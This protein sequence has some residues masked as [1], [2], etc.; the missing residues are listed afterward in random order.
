MSFREFFLLL[1]H[2]ME[3]RV[4]FSSAEWF[5]I[6]VQ[7]FASI[8]VPR[9]EIPSCFLFC[10]RVP[11]EL[12]EL[13]SIFVSSE[14]NSELFS[15]PRK[16][17]ERNS[18][19]FL[20][21]GTAGIPSEIAICFVFRRFFLSEIPNPNSKWMD[22]GHWCLSKFPIT[23]WKCARQLFLLTLLMNLFLHLN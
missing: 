22:I 9:N 4:V 12:W 21:C 20:F 18:E 7:E 23:L 19:S 10:R 6:E 17:L 14:R 5:G 3:F 2:A 13:A 11:M 8:F 1:Y 16:D 15:L